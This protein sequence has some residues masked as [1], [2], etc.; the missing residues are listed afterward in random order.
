MKTTTILAALVIVT[1]QAAIGA[2]IKNWPKWMQPK[3][4]PPTVSTP[5]SPVKPMDCSQCTSATVAVKHDLVAG[6]PGHGYRYVSQTVHQCNGC[7]D[8]LARKSATKTM[9]L[10]HNCTAAGEKALCCATRPS[11]VG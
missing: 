3:Q 11:K 7:R 5:A 10:A 6:K 9:E 8:T 4:N 2:E 1:A